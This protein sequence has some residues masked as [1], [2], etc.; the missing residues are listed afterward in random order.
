MD[1]CN[2]EGICQQN[3]HMV[4]MYC[5]LM[6]E[7]SD[8][9]GKVLPLMFIEYYSEKE[10]LSLEYNHNHSESGICFV[11]VF[12]TLT[13][14]STDISFLLIYENQESAVISEN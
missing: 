5:G 9:N 4:K 8:I 1:G 7:H 3:N 10:N 11:Q 13:I 14:L 6:E 2:A 12:T